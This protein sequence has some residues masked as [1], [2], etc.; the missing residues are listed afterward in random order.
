MGGCSQGNPLSFA[1]NLAFYKQISYILNMSVRMRIN[2]SATRM[3]RSHHAL[4]E[5][6]VSK[7]AKCGAAHLRHH[8]CLACGTYRSK[9]V[10]DVL[11]KTTKKEAK[12]KKRA[13][14]EGK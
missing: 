3:R 4:S 10:I 2:R 11:A 7:C 9:M 13:G 8:A 6:R 14:K 5:A 12:R 1:P